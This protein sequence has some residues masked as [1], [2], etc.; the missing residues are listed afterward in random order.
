MLLTMRRKLRAARK[1]PLIVLALFPIAWT[2]TG[3]A[4]MV[5][6]LVPF[7]KIAPW[8]G[9]N[10]GAVALSPLGNSSTDAWALRIGQAVQIAARNSPFRA[11]CLPQAL[12][13]VALCRLAGL[14]TALHLGSNV[15]RAG[16]EKQ[17]EAHA[18]VQSGRVNVTG[19]ANSIK[20][21]AAV[22]CFLRTPPSRQK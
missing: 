4:A 1:Q 21:Y 16:A 20:R 22:A 9:Q 13:A 14:P 10:C 17:M 6:K 3:L 18:W 5:L 15:P 8:L 7:R 19:G 11:D 12:A 2:A